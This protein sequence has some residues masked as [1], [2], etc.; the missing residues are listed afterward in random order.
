METEI[1]QNFTY[2][3]Q[4]VLLLLN[5]EVGGLNVIL[6]LRQSLNHQ[7]LSSFFY[8][9]HLLL[10]RFLLIHPSII[11]PTRVEYQ[12]DWRSRRATILLLLSTMV[13]I[14][15]LL[16]SK[17]YRYLLF[18][19]TVFSRQS[20]CTTSLELQKMCIRDRHNRQ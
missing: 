8:L 3:K 9:V 20:S 16:S 12:F 6:S 11:P 1:I 2:R 13:A 15:I 4:G 5:S 19:P 17:P 14:T 18:L 10:F 7:T